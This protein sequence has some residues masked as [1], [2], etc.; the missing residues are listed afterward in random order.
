MK[1]WIR[2]SLSLLLVLTGLFSITM[3]LKSQQEK[4]AGGN[5]YENALALATAGKTSQTEVPQPQPKRRNRE[6][7]NGSQPLWKRKIPMYGRWKN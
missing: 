7:P 1:K 5:S 4:T 6:N 2:K 3:F